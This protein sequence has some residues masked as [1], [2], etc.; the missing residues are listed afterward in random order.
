ML[1]DLLEVGG[2]AVPEPGQAFVDVGGSFVE[3][4]RKAFL[5]KAAAISSIFP[6]MRA[7]RVSASRPLPWVPSPGL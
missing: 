5:R 4:G 3:P 2:I 6:L 7:A 1:E